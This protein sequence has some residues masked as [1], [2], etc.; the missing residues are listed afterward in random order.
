[1]SNLEHLPDSACSWTSTPMPTPRKRDQAGFL[2]V[3]LANSVMPR[4]KTAAASAAKEIAYH[5][6]LHRRL[7]YKYDYMFRPRELSF[8]LDC[9]TQTHEL[10]GPILEIGCAGG[11]TTVFLNK[12]LDDLADS[13][14]YTCIDTF[15]G[16]T[17]QDI[18]VEDG[19][20]KDPNLYANLFRAYRKKWFDRTMTNNGVTRVEAIEADV[21]E[22]DFSSIR[23][24]SFC[25]VDVDLKR[26]VVRSLQQVVPR[27]APGGIVV[28]DDC[29]PDAKFDG[30]LSGYLEVTGDHGLPTD[31]RHDKLGVIRIADIPH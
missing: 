25:L 16:F 20:G 14:S 28:V 10:R 1:M 22:F 21:N 13:R 2:P 3:R 19:R 30:A 17:D 4:T 18:A 8:L 12:H 9:L 31:I 15:A 6:G 5:T 29:T 11:H 27:M 26:P 7:F 24:I 23:N